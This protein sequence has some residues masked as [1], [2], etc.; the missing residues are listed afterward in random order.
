MVR[1]AHRTALAA[2]ALAVAG[3]AAAVLLATGAIG[4]SSDRVPQV[5]AQ[6]RPATV[7]VVTQRGGARTGTGSGFVLDARR[8]LIATDAHVVNQGT[9]FQVV[10][11]GR[12]RP[13]TV[14]GVAPCEDLALLQVADARGLHA[15][16]L[17]SGVQQGETAVALGYSDGGFT[18]TAGVVSAARTSFRDPAPDVPAYPEV[19]QTD[20]ALN[21]GDSGGPLANLDGEV[22][23]VDAAARTTG[24]D[25]RALQNVN[26]AIPIG[27]ARR[28]LAGLAAGRSPAWTGLT[29][30]YPTAADLRAA[31]LPSGLRVTG[32]IPGTP[33]AGAAIAPGALLAGSDGHRLDA[34]LS[35][36]CAAT[37]GLRSGDQV[38][39]SFAA[40]GA[41]LTRQL[42]LR[43]G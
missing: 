6:L 23:A 42:R 13:A 7:L 33:A 35:S 2:A 1:R 22:I 8:G 30:A 29:F 36:Y 5:V 21:P 43:L 25:G 28:V 16:P 15:A 40:P 17:G 14:R 9:A 41:A 37:A 39:L 31:R 20:T 24:S 12:A 34:T 19:V 3:V 38:V 18:A 4:G 11:A 10:A 32:A 27:R 26:Y